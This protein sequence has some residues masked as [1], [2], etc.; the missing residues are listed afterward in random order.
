MIHHERFPE[1]DIPVFRKQ[2]SA[3]KT[4]SQERKTAIEFYEIPD[5]LN[6]SFTYKVYKNDELAKQL[7]RV[8]MNKCAYCDCNYKAGT[9]DD[10][11]HFRP[12]GAVNKFVGFV[13]Q[14]ESDKPGY[15]WLAADW[16]NL[17]ISC[18]RCNRAEK[19]DTGLSS[20]LWGKKDRFPVADE[21]KRARKPEADLASEGA[22]LINPCIDDPEYFFTYVVEGN[23]KEIGLVKPKD[24]LNA[25]EKKRAET[26]WIVYALNRPPLVSERNKCVTD[27]K[28]DISQLVT[29][30]WI[31]VKRNQIPGA[32]IIYEKQNLD[33]AIERLKSA[34]EKTAPFL[35][36]K[37]QM[38]RQALEWEAVKELK[39]KLNVDLADFL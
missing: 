5:N 25:D 38:F 9:P 7:N 6:K 14:K 39:Q 37:R 20:E 23:V 30:L 24:E 32:D 36:V 3:K 1:P 28:R 27:L 8:F 13:D 31:F 29:A 12:K 22:L 18:P 16:D 10:I 19:Y 4:A 2:P 11:E 15:Y 17:F 34:I 26:S 35:G 21:T 33:L